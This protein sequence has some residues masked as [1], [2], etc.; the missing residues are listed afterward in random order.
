MLPVPRPSSA[1][2]AA[3]VAARDPA[4]ADVVRDSP[5]FALRRRAGPG[6]DAFNVLAASIVYQQLAGKAAAAI[7]GRFLALF[8]GHATPQAVLATPVETLRSV[9]LSGNKAASILD[10]AAKVADGT[11]P[12]DR[13]GRLKDDDI[14]ARLVQVRGI[15]RWTAE[16]FLIFNLRRL[17]VWP[18]D[19][20]GVRKGW[21]L[22]HGMTELPKP[23]ALDAEGEVFRPYRTGAAWY[24]W[25]A[26][27]TLLPGP[28]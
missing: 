15:G 25:R 2:V 16:M 13:L 28:L 1:A 6:T 3:E 22:L 24:C 5:P 10:L 8:D 26:V 20:Y 7:H 23:K 19:D 4:F 21:A 17:D 12:V 14:V 27:E 9:G 18:V 11:V